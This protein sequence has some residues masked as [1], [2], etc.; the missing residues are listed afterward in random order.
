MLGLPRRIGV[1]GSGDGLDLGIER[2]DQ[3]E[4]TRRRRDVLAAEH[5]RSPRGLLLVRRHLE[6]D[7]E[8]CEQARERPVDRVEELA[9][10][11]DGE[12]GHV[13]GRD[14]AP[15]THARLQ[16]LHVDAVRREVERGREPRD[17]AADHDDVVRW[18][19]R[20]CAQCPWEASGTLP[21]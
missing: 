8:R 15:E 6:L 1:D 14:A 12:A 5:D 2:R 18:R 7:T 16:E 10:R 21:R 9:A 4:R 3:L 20:H 13:T 11:L 19:V 17:A